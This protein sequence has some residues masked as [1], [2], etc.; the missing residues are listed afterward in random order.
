VAI[1]YLRKHCVSPNLL[2]ILFVDCWETGR[3]GQP[4]PAPEK[5]SEIL[6]VDDLGAHPPYLVVATM[7]ELALGC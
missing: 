7:S 1:A 3:T 6:G 4:A 5:G 2:F